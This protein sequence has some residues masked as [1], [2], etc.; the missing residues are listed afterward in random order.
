MNKIDQKP[1]FAVVNFSVL[2]GPK[3]TGR[4]KFSLQTSLFT[5]NVTIVWTF[6]APVRGMWHVVPAE[7]HMYVLGFLGLLTLLLLLLARLSSRCVRCSCA[8]GFDPLKMCHS[9]LSHLVFNLQVSCSQ[10]VEFFMH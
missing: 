9:K 3:T 2:R 5:G 1:G 7:Y 8:F 10:K 4:L 6:Q